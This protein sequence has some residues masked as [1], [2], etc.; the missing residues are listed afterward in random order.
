VKR[1]ILLIALV[2]LVIILAGL[3]ASVVSDT[4]PSLTDSNIPNNKV[5][6]N[7]TQAN[8]SSAIATIT[9]TMYAVD[10]E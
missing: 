1:L 6:T 4:G 3:P 8:N 2:V 9:I 5:T 7:Q 10:G